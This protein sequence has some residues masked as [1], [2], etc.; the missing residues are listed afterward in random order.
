MRET[1]KAEFQT[2]DLRVIGKAPRCPVCPEQYMA[3]LNLKSDPE[4]CQCPRCG[5]QA[6]FQWVV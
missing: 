1:K 5:R 3:P 4:M 6:R 2:K